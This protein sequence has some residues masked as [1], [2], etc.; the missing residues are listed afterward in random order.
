[1]E[2]QLNNQ[3]Q[4][5]NLSL[6]GFTLDLQRLQE[7]QSKPAPFTAGEPHFWDDPY[8]SQQMLRTHLDSTTDA[9]SRRPEIIDQSVDWMIQ[10][11]HLNPENAILDLGC[12]PG[13]YTLRLARH[14]IRV[15]GVD[16]SQRS[17]AY[18]VEQSQQ[19][20]L[21]I[22]YRC[23]N[24][25]LLDDRS[26]YDVALLIYGDFCPLSP[27][28]RSKLLQNVH[29][30]LKPDG[31]FVL[32]VST[33]VHRQRYGRR[34]AWYATENGF[35]KAGPHL[36]LEQGFDYPEQAIY[37]DQYVVIEAD[38]NLSVYRNWF[39]DY[40][41][42]SITAELEA[43]GFKVKNLYADLMGTPYSDDTEWIGVVAQR[44]ES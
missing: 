24:Y 2:V 35:W 14:G 12:G 10:S 32:D 9:A 42:G 15:T 26:L 40:N 39:Q 29:R 30:A 20:G 3:D 11:L 5:Q 4:Q 41:A 44:V 22:D 18:A 31:L 27:E 16:L 38:S 33:R 23:Q 8:I 21:Q 7:L 34:N 28:K 37:L 17:I 6:K 36:V 25:L 13:L 19:Q 43:G 1:M